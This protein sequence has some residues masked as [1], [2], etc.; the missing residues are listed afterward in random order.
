MGNSSGK[1]N[2]IEEELKAK[3]EELSIKL[4]ESQAQLDQ[5]KKKTVEIHQAKEAKKKQQESLEKRVKMQQWLS[6]VKQGCTSCF[7]AF[8]SKEE[9]MMRDLKQLEDH[10]GASQAAVDSLSAKRKDLEAKVEL[11]ETMAIVPPQNSWVKAEEKMAP[12]FARNV[13][14]FRA[15]TPAQQ[16]DM[17]FKIQELLQDLQ[18]CEEECQNERR[19]QQQAEI[20][21]MQHE[22]STIAL[23]KQLRSQMR[24]DAGL[25][26]QL[27][28]MVNSE[29]RDAKTMATK[30]KTMFRGQTPTKQ[31]DM[32]EQIKAFYSDLLEAEAEADKEH[33]AHISIRQRGQMLVPSS[34][35]SANSFAF[36]A[37]K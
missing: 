19:N 29:D 14:F 36:R 4:G 13:S 33:Q 7:D 3:M 16:R 23:E 27:K 17:K 28:D 1:S 8:Y 22:V 35:A 34:N 18:A 25:D 5:E 30:F 32:K 12:L 26:M 31:R 2:T 10:L 21:S 11:Q 15:K 24:V 20:D 9:R 37:P 6:P